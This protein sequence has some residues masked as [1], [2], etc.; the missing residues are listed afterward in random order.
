MLK[1]NLINYIKDVMENCNNLED[2][3]YKVT[4]KALAQKFGVKRNTVSHYLNQ[5]VGNT[6]IKINTRPVYFLYR[7]FFE[8]E[9]FSLSK[10]IYN[11]INELLAEIE[12]HRKNDINLITE[13]NKSDILHCMIGYNGSLKKAVEQIKASVF[14]PKSSL[15]IFLYGATGVGKSYIAKL[16]YQFSVEN[17]VL[18]ENAPYITFNCAQYANNPE[19]LAS[20]LFGYVKGS[21]TGAYKTTKGFLE[22]ADGGMLFL[23]EI[24]RL[25][26]EGQE[27]LFIFLDQGIFHRMGENDTWHKANV[28]IVM[29]TTEDLCSNFLETFLRRIPIFINIPS[30]SERPY[31]ERLQFVYY[32]FE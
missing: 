16:I 6:L 5:A 10:C 3:L 1:D 8:K 31:N 22:A 29:A 12:D 9:C 32:F 23:D 17:G 18:P 27:K 4:A 24:H 13:N 28:R 19:L 7:K 11:S 25:N 14:Y 30:L 21:F 15:P 20:S 2:I 26:S